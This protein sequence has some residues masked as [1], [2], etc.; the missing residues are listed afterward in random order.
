MEQNDSRKL[1]MLYELYEQ[2]MYRIAYA[3]LHNREQAEDAVSDAFIRI[4][5]KL[6]KIG[7]PD[8]PKTKGY[9]VKVIKSTSVSI[10]RR[11]KRRFSHEM[12]VSSETMQIPDPFS[13]VEDSVLAA[14]AA[15]VLEGVDEDD[16]R[17]LLLRCSCGMQWKEVA[18]RTSL[19]EAAVRKRFERARKRII[20]A[21]GGNNDE[22]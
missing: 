9:I 3:F 19:S 7:D 17:I 6:R 13:A 4:I 8:S 10:Y 11:N 14:D 12:P 2:P 21:K 22:N 15:R 5:G 16:R 1:E 18:E 20:K